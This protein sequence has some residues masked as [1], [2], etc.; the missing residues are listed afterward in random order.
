FSALSAPSNC[1]Q[2]QKTPFGEALKPP[3]PTNS[4]LNFAAFIE[5]FSF[6]YMATNCPFE[7]LCPLL[8]K[9]MGDYLEQF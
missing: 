6:L 2:R 5:K 7:S 3:I 8:I 1:V 4:F 9:R